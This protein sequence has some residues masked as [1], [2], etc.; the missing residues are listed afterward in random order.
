MGAIQNTLSSM[1]NDQ[2]METYD[3][4][5]MEKRM[6]EYNAKMTAYEQAQKARA[7]KNQE[8]NAARKENDDGDLR[9][10]KNI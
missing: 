3:R 5:I 2:V 8:A 10:N 7:S 4:K 1:E 9:F 6:A